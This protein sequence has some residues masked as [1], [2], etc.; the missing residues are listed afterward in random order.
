MLAAT[1]RSAS[2]AG[3]TA[4][5]LSAWRE[6]LELLPPGSRQ[7]EIIQQKIGELVRV[8]Q[9][10][11]APVPAP[12]TGTPPPSAKSSPGKR[13]AAGLGA[14]GLLLL[15]FKTL[16]LILLTK[17]KLLLLGLTKAGT[18]FSMLLSMG[19]YWTLWGWKFAVGFVLSIYVH[20]M[21]HV[22]ALQRYGFK[23]TAPMF[24][25]GLGAFIRLQQQVINPTEDA[26]IGLAG[27][28]YGLGAAAVSLGLWWVT[29]QPLFAALAGVGAW[30]NLFNLIPVWTLDGGRAFHALSRAQKWMMAGVAAAAWFYTNDGIL[31]LVMIACIGR[32]AVDKDEGQSDR[33]AA[34]TYSGLV[35]VLSVLSLARPHGGIHR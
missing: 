34:L 28:I 15:K 27:P 25:P 5:A 23:A 35:I 20:E 8:V 2:E 18:L 22:I 9:T 32:A 6:A 29:K 14:L 24:I 3:N 19:V 4:G 7:F 33:R 12:T 10:G 31:L 17:G 21:G 1:A 11:V 30:I 16:L 26:V 13:A